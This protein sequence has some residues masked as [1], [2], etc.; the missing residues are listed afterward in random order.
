LLDAAPRREDEERFDR[1][2]QL[3]MFQDRERHL[4]ETLARR[5][6]RATDA[7]DP[8]AVFNAAQ[9]HLLATARANID[10][11]LLQAFADGAERCEDE[12]GRAALERLCDLFAMSTI[13]AERGW[14]QEHGRLSS[15]RSKAVVAEVNQ[16]CEEL[17]PL[18]LTFTEA[19]AIPDEAIA[20]PI[21]LGAELRREQE[22]GRTD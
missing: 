7:E 6:R 14:F 20:A 9:D 13:E 11:V 5:L 19:F 17:R 8:F 21:A 3:E 4:L 18:A 12:A 22:A 1:S 10:L 15:T 16:L 2:W